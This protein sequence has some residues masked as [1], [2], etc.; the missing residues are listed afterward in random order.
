MSEPVS[1][2]GEGE[3]NPL[4]GGAPEAVAGSPTVAP[5][6]YAPTPPQIP[7]PGAKAGRWRRILLLALGALV[8]LL[9]AL[10]AL[11]PTI[12]SS[13]WARRTVEERASSASGRRVGIGALDVGWSSTAIRELEVR[14]GPGEGDPILAKIG[15]IRV[16]AGITLGFADRW[17]LGEVEILRPEIRVDLRELSKP[18]APA[19]APAAGKGGAGG[20]RGGPGGGGEE[21]KA[22]P[23]SGKVRVRDG[24]LV[25]VGLDGKETRLG[26]F[27]ADLAATSEGECGASF[28]LD[29]GTGGRVSLRMEPLR[30]KGDRPSKWEVP[31]AGL[32]LAFEAL[33][34]APFRE[35]AAALGDAGIDELRGTISGS[36]TGRVPEGVHAMDGRISLDVRGL[37]V[38]GAAVNGGGR[39]EEPE[40][41]LEAGHAHSRGGAFEVRDALL[42]LR[43]IEVK[44][45][46]TVAADRRISGKVTATA[47]LGG[48]AE[49]MKRLR[50]PFDGFL[51]G[52]ASLDVLATAD[53]HGQR[54]TGSAKVVDGGVGFGPGREPV[55]EPLVD[56]EFD[57]A[58][59]GTDWT[60]SAASLRS[61][62]ADLTCG[63]TFR[64]DLSAADLKAGG[65]VRLGP[66]H[67]IA[68]AFGASLPGEVAGL[69]DLDVR[70]LRTGKEGDGAV[71]TLVV[72]DLA[73][74]P[75][76]QGAK[77]I[78]EPRLE[79]RF[80]AVPGKES[81]EVRS[82]TV[83]GAGADVRAAG[84]AAMD[85]ASGA[86]ATCEATLDLEKAAALAVCFGAALPAR[87]AG[88]ASWKGPISW[89]GGGAEAT[90]KGDLLVRDFVATLPASGT[91]PERTLREREV[92]VAV[93]ATARRRK[94]GAGYDVA[95]GPTAVVAEG[96][97]AEAEGSV[98]AD[99]T[100]DVRAKG[101]LSLAGALGRAA[102]LGF[103]PKDPSAKG[104]LAFDLS[105]KGRP[106]ELETT[107]R[108]L[109]AKDAEFDLHASG[110]LAMKGAGDLALDAGGDVA[111]LLGLA[112]RAGLMEPVK[113]AAGKTTLKGTVK[114]AGPDDP[115]RLS[116]V[117]DV[118]GLRWP[119]R[120]G[121][122]PWT[123]GSVKA[124]VDASWDRGK[125]TA[126]GTAVLRG[127]DGTATV[128]GSA[129]LAEGRREM[130]AS[131]DLDL[132]LGGVLRSRPDLLPLPGMSIGRAKGTARLKGPLAS[133]LELPKLRGGAKLVLDSVKTE[134]LELRDA[135]VDALFQQGTL[136][137]QALT[138]TVNGGKV[139]GKGALGFSGA[140]P[141]HFLEAKATGI[142]ID[143][144]MEYLLVKV[145][146]LFSVGE[147]GGVSGELRL[148]LRLD[149][150]GAD[151][152]SAKK[153]MVGKG[154][155][156]VADGNVTGSGFLGD[157]LELVGGGNGIAFDSVSTAF[158]VHD[159]KVWNDRLLVDGKE[160]SLVFRGTTSFQ[161]DLEYE[162][163]IR[164]A[165]LGKKVAERLA[166]ILDKDGNLVLEV[167]GNVSKPRVKAPKLFK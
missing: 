36:V 110:S 83:T 133:P 158:E 28:S 97:D 66:A 162:V 24:T 73:V 37:V 45:G 50:V 147:K 79:A 139:Q 40:I 167:R 13:G 93:D 120:A 22:T 119:D 12:L 29:A 10:A 21:R 146:P 48:V 15:E 156:A 153:S 99:G 90:A 31:E 64:S 151:W 118:E 141:K 20:K 41:H 92:R 84:S 86:L 23:F 7:V 55:L 165:R 150:S 160:Q 39:I 81:L 106:A 125:E 148:D 59:A 2:S 154:S 105:A 46:A 60:L 75:P 107:I 134:P 77:E 145:V 43:G 87:V 96:V 63:G 149:A 129:V 144:A 85:G 3:P 89:K 51:Q 70:L 98:A 123:Q 82:L 76:G 6:D 137:I 57:L 108:S 88:T 8:V 152:L 130:D 65:K 71:G 54:Y 47:S 44:G 26:G 35:A 11:L 32:E 135:S 18:A 14:W 91:D 78:R 138:A 95:L 142:R 25:V 4:S 80:D 9:G 74:L 164:A 17:D 161:G 114:A 58:R 111:A 132:D 128:T 52:D 5:G 163:G 115:L 27:A 38:A 33:D 101:V 157:L 49:R 53:A 104:D 112:A 62:T 103:L 131:V 69:A 124:M 94:D 116:L 127:D 1:A 34:L 122:A 155:L 166:P 19:A 42:R 126:S 159:R 72:T 140:E 61:R 113:D 30:F 109:D 121:G 143:P 56:A 68:R 100:L 136:T 117:G 102:A 67:R 16:P